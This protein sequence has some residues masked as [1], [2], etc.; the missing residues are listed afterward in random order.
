M[1]K[2]IVLVS[3]LFICT[4]GVLVYYF[5]DYKNYFDK[6][7]G[8]KLKNIFEFCIVNPSRNNRESLLKMVKKGK[9]E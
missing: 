7:I 2:I 6:E 3:I 5:F 8:I 4:M 1:K 9:G